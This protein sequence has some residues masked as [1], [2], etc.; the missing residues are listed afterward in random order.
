MFD[1]FWTVKNNET[2]SCLQYT[3]KVL[4][5]KCTFKYRINMRRNIVLISQAN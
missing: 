1:Y 5:K 4:K 3:F 2:N